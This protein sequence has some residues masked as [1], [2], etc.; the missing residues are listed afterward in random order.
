MRNIYRLL[1]AFAL[2]AAMAPANAQHGAESDEIQT[3]NAAEEAFT[4]LSALAGMWRNADDAD[5]ALRVHFYL[6]ARGT[7]LVEEWMAGDRPHSLTLYH[8]AG[9]TLM[10]T[11]YCPQGNQPRLM[12]SER[13]ADDAIS[14]AFFD[15][16]DLSGDESALHDLAIAIVGDDRIVRSET[17]RQGSESA[18]STL[19][20]VR[21]E[22]E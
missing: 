17:Y 16:T 11:H 3:A 1:A 21:A 6:T 18:P 12:L 19:N 20:L 10:V 14:F 5:S 13:E 7:T 9:P 4:R 15:A 8:L 2:G 22:A